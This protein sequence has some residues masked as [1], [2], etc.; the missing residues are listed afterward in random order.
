MYTIKGIDELARQLTLALC[1]IIAQSKFDD[2]KYTVDFSRRLADEDEWA[3]L[4]AASSYIEMHD[5]DPS[6]AMELARRY[7]RALG[8]DHDVIERLEGILERIGK[9]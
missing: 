5:I 6:S 4:E 7:D 2:A 9:A 8:Y 3:A 1:D